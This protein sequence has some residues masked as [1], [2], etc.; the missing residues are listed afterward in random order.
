[1]KTIL[2]I[3][4]YRRIAF[5]LFFFIGYVAHAQNPPVPIPPPEGAPIDA[6]LII[7][8]IAALLFGT[9]IIYNNQLNKKRAI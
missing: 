3:A 2:S 5:L 9:Y 4:L 1:M 7:L 8:L 6:N